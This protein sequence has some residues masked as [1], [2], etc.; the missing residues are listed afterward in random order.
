MGSHQDI[1]AR[2]SEIYQALTKNRSRWV[3]NSFMQYAAVSSI[4]SQQPAEQIA[5]SVNEIADQIKK[6]SGWFGELNGCI[7]FVIAAMIENQGDTADAFMDELERVRAEFRTEKIR[8]GGLYEIVAITIF[9]LCG[10]KNGAFQTISSATIDR[11]QQIYLAMSKNQWW[12]TAADDFPACAILALQPGDPVE[13]ANQCETIYQALVANGFWKGNPL[14][15][16][17]NL[18]YLAGDRPDSVASRFHEIEQTL[19][20]NKVRVW[21]SEYDEVAILTF[22]HQPS[23]VLVQRVKELQAALMSLKPKI[24]K[25]T[26]FSLACSLCFMESAEQRS[27]SMITDAKAMMDL[28]AIIAA[29]QAAMMGSMVAVSV[30]VSASSSS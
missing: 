28:N 1:L 9:R 13:M 10:K 20:A 7:R 3:D 29:Q 19:K 2:Y 25:P 16:V 11:F 22:C 8:R 17:A 24:Y 5:E 14:Q 23:D 21:Q 26:A 12:L 15:A 27:S 4:K 30:A 6:R 18:L